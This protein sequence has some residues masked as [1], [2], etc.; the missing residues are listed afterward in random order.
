MS[1]QYAAFVIGAYA[2]TGAALFAIIGWVLMDRRSARAELSRAER[3]YSRQKEGR[4][5]A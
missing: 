4:D 1:G 5:G 2:V 3:A